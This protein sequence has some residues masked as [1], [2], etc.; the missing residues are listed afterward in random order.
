MPF[1]STLLIVIAGAAVAGFVQGLSGFAFGMVAMSFWAWAIE[2]RL[3]AAMTVFGAL[4]GQLLAAASV[5]R[6]LSWRRLWPFVAGGVAGIPLGV[7]VLPLLDAQ[8]FKA[9][10]GAFLTLWCPVMLMARRLPHIGVGGRVA[11]GMAGAAGGVMGGIGGFTGV[12]PT[13]WCTL[14]GFDK[15]EQRAVIQ[16]FNLATLAMTM[17]AYVGKGIVTREMLPMFLVVAPAMLVPTLLGTRL[18]LG[19]SEAAFRK[20]VLSLLTLSGVALLVTSVPVLVA[21]GAG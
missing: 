10:L 14:R 13:L 3:A 20:I 4:T 2:P 1:D 18:Y 19:I 9:V 16:N 17:A 5:R 7:A 12:I 21:R 6:G 15:D 11:D 8:W